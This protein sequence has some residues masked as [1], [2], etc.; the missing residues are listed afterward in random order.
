MLTT[1]V[2]RR[3]VRDHDRVRSSGRQRGR[4]ARFRHVGAGDA[5]REISGPDENATEARSRPAGRQQRIRIR[6]FDSAV[7][8]E[9]TDDGPAEDV[10]SRS[11]PR[12]LDSAARNDGDPDGELQL[13]LE[14]S[15]PKPRGYEASADPPGERSDTARWLWLAMGVG[16]VTCPILLAFQLVFTNPAHGLNVLAV[17]VTMSFGVLF[18]TWTVEYWFR[19]GDRRQ[20]GQAAEP[21]AY[22][23]CHPGVGGGGRDGRE[24]T[25]PHG[26]FRPA[27]PG[28]LHADRGRCRA[29]PDAHSVVGADAL[30]DPYA[31]IADLYEAEHRGWVERPGLISRVGLPRRC[32]GVGTGLRVGTRS[33]GPGRSRT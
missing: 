3:A 24:R 9:G 31:P 20:A 28:D 13:T 19:R 6:N 22:S 12:A 16:A 4:P 10:E 33:D 32:P 11:T 25:E 21:G 18:A 29:E 15:E 2:N 26:Q 17:V 23:P 5:A 7:L 1:E 27:D 8:D 30:D 14:L